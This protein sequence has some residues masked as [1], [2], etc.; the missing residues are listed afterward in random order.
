MTIGIGL[1]A[2][3]GLILGADSL[4][5]DGYSKTYRTKVHT[6]W[7][8]PRSRVVVVEAGNQPHCATAIAGIMD[9]LKSLAEPF[10][11]VQIQEA[12]RCA[13][14]RVHADIDTTNPD[15]HVYLL[16]G[17]WHA[18]QAMSRL[19]V[20]D[21]ANVFTFYESSSFKAIGL[22]LYVAQMFLKKAHEYRLRTATATLLAA[23][24][25]NACKQHVQS[26]G[27]FTEIRILSNSGSIITVPRPYIEMAED[28]MESLE[29]DLCDLMVEA[30]DS[31]ID[32]D[33]LDMDLK[34][35]DSRIRNL[36]LAWCWEQGP[37]V[38]FR[39][40]IKDLIQK[41]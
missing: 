9:T 24:A 41:R 21:A 3:D 20:I 25:I 39:A 33:R 18:D 15:E 14:S 37:D 29:K 10:G 11:F 16:A 30:L 28:Y 2:D 36:R 32:G 7:D 22:G 35:M 1:I 34:H 19:L 4:I 40:A 6:I 38:L 13:C 8:T 27:G 5:T 17:V 31:S 26:C 12:I 23:R